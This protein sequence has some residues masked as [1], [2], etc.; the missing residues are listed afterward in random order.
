MFQKEVANRILARSNTKDFGRLAILANWRLEVKK[1]FDISK[2]CFFP[3]PKINSTVLSFTPKK[4]NIPNLND[5]KNLEK[6]TR[7]LFSNRRKMINKNFK[8]LFKEKLFDIKNLDIDLSKRPG[9]LS[10]D[11]FYKIAIEYEKLFN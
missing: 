2:N 4:N 7:V 10:S 3:K 1:H 5:P 11:T 6:I 9:E 8:K